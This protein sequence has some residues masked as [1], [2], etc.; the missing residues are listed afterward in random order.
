MESEPRKLVV[1]YSLSGNT[2]FIGKTIA[3]TIGADVL[4]LMLKKEM[5]PRGFMKYV[6]GGKQVFRKE[7]PELLPMDKEPSSYDVLF[8][9]TPV[10]AFSFTPAL[11]TFFENVK[12]SGK[13]IA[14]FCC[15]GGGPGKTVEKMK[16]QLAGNDF[17]GEIGFIEPLRD[18]HKNREKAVNW[19]REIMGKIGTQS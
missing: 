8:I 3:E 19:A 5:K 12:L 16:K 10:W 2:A 9:G 11:R 14:L 18:K 6:R 13:K 17:I 4:E 7:K 1:Y 15:S